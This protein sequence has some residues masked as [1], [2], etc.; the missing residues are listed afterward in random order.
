MYIDE[1][2]EYPVLTLNILIHGQAI[3]IPEEQF[4]NDGKVIK[5]RQRYIKC[6]K[7]AALN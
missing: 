6:C 5:K 4:D 1:D 3:T 2:I 7:K